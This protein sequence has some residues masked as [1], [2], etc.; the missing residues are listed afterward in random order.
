VVLDT[1][2]PVQAKA[3]EAL[4]PNSTNSA[5]LILR[6]S[7]VAG[8]RGWGVFLEY[9]KA[10]IERTVVRDTRPRIWNGKK[11][12]G[13]GIITRSSDLELTDSLVVDNHGNVS[14]WGSDAVIERTLITNTR[15]EDKIWDGGINA[16]ACSVEEAGPGCPVGRATSLT[17]RDSLIENH[18]SSGV[19]VVESTA[20]VEDSV[21]QNNHGIGIL[22]SGSSVTVNR[23][24]VRN[25]RTSPEPTNIGFSGMGIAAGSDPTK[26]QSTPFALTVADS[27]V[28]QND[29]VGI[30][31]ASSRATIKRSVVR[32]TQAVEDKLGNE[33]GVGI[34][35][36]VHPYDSGPATLTLRDSLVKE[37]THAGVLVYSSRATVQR[38]IIRDSRAHEE[39]FG[40]G[41]TG[42]PYEDCGEPELKLEDSWVDASARA[43]VLLSSGGGSVHRSAL[44]RGFFSIALEQGASLEIGDDNLL[45]DNKEDRV[46]LG[47]QLDLPPLPALPQL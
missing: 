19:H 32:R 22:A 4:A 10:H 12:W 37:N 33:F 40:D 6:D 15:A 41:I 7:L 38:S 28:D 31:V 3:V 26:E 29:Y 39:S 43:G 44:S 36:G 21:L 30:A 42:A 1:S 27:I 24:I 25:T 9:A 13:L 34:Y 16:A 17:L 14:L 18:W 5:S 35:A 45:V 23:S 20:T 8:S 46:T 11:L 47:Q 2:N